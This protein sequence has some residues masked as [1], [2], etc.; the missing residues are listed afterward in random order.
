MARN[1][2]VTG[3]GKQ[4]PREFLERK[5]R[6]NARG[7]LSSGRS[8][9]DGKS[10]PMPEL[11][12][13][14]S[15]DVQEN[16]SGDN[17]GRVDLRENKMAVPFAPPVQARAIQVHEQAHVAW[18]PRDEDPSTV[19]RRLSEVTK[20]DIPPILVN[21]CEDARINQLLLNAGVT[22]LRDAPV[23]EG[24]PKVTKKLRGDMIHE[25]EMGHL[26]KAVLLWVI[27]YAA[28]HGF[29]GR[30]ASDLRR[31]L[32]SVN[33]TTYRRLRQQ[34]KDAQKRGDATE[35]GL[36][37]SRAAT[38]TSH[39]GSLSSSAH[40][41]LRRALVDPAVR[42]FDTGTEELVT[43]LAILLSRALR[44]EREMGEEELRVRIAADRKLE[45]IRKA[46]GT[47][48]GMPGLDDMI[49]SLARSCGLEDV[50][51]PV[52]SS[53]RRAGPDADMSDGRDAKWGQMEPLLPPLS[54]RHLK[55]V[56][57]RRGRYRSSDSGAILRYIHRWWG[58]DRRVFGVKRRTHGAS[59][60]FDV[61]GSMGLSVR[62]VEEMLKIVPALTVA[63]YSGRQDMGRLTLLAYNGRRVKEIPN[64]GMMGGNVV[65]GPALVWLAQQPKP[66]IWVSDGYVTGVRDD[67]GGGHV[68]FCKEVCERGDIVRVPNVE[69]AQHLLKLKVEV[70]R[71]KHS[72][73]AYAPEHQSPA[74]SLQS[75]QV[76]PS[77][78][79]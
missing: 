22:A 59:V 27:H 41:A 58:G 78:G 62:D 31:V 25:V 12:H 32:Q 63:M 67:V 21:A 76:S 26:E 40:Y 6:S 47:V 5:R 33:R 45:D 70:T 55:A 3:T 18:T 50:D 16:R 72:S 38:V 65:D 54:V 60:L 44:I 20:V 56:K 71:R 4:D 7:V 43:R 17:S 14:E 1:S 35:A 64:A 46:V 48:A 61:S 49:R 36:L 68:E 30:H 52:E 57:Q 11:L 2:G 23:A 77:V 9:R 74:D 19:A 79:L 8:R 28:A 53:V 15:W 66:R 73:L 34:A 13:G 10:R 42:R 75:I 39:L 37:Y 29:N 24:W 69:L 51:G